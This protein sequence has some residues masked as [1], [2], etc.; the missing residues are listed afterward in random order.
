MLPDG[1][2]I[3]RR[4]AENAEVATSKSKSRRTRRLGGRKFPARVIAL[5][6][7]RST[8]PMRSDFSL[9]IVFH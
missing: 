3:Q 2:K 9:D 1:E 5:I 7:H 4:V 8:V 6:V